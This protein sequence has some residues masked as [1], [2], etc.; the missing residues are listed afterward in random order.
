MILIN[1]LIIASNSQ[2]WI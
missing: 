2:K 1:D